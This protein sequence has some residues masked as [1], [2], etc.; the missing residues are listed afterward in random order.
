MGALGAAAT[1]SSGGNFFGAVRDSADRFCQFHQPLLRRY[2]VRSHMR[3]RP[4]VT[5]NAYGGTIRLTATVGAE[6]SSGVLSGE[7]GAF[8][9]AVEEKWT[10]TIPLVSP[11][12]FIYSISANIVPISGGNPDMVL[13]RSQLVFPGD[14]SCRANAP[15]WDVGMDTVR[16]EIADCFGDS[17]GTSAHEYGHFI[18]FGDAYDRQTNAILTSQTD[19]MASTIGAVQWYHARLLIEKYEGR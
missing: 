11:S 15:H 14:N 17:Y 9:T 18:G 2:A 12:G 10:T 1:G 5:G 3:A 7:V 19:L 13:K 6:P 16:A 8:V 4:V